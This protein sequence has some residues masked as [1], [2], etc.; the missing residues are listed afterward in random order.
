MHQQ[1]IGKFRAVALTI[2]EDCFNFKGLTQIAV[3]SFNTL[4]F[5]FVPAELTGGGKFPGCRSFSSFQIPP[6]G[7][8]LISLLFS[9]LFFFFLLSYMVL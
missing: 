2:V 4:N 5:L 9:S 7:V 1:M 3:F 8:G 6:R